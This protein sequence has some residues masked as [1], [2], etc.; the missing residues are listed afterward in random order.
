MNL[1]GLPDIEFAA[2]DPETIKNAV[3]SAAERTHEEATGEKITLYPADPRRLFL[4]TVAEIII[5]QRNLIDYTGKMN[6][7]A[8]ATGD[9]L[10]HLGALLGVE[11][12]PARAARTTV[13]FTLS[14][15]QAR[16]VS[17]PAG[18]RTSA[19][20]NVYFQSLEEA[21]IPAGKA[22][23][24]VS[25][26]CA[27]IGILGN[28]YLPG[29]IK[30]LVDPLP[31][32]QSVVNT[33][34]SEG[35][36]DAED[37]ENYRERIQ[38]A[39]EQY[40]N[41]GSRDAYVSWARRAS[42]LIADVGVHSPS[43]GVVN[44]YPL[45]NDGGLPGQEILD[46]VLAVCNGEDVRPLTDRVFALSPD[47]AEYELKLTWY[48]DRGNATSASSIHNA[49]T[50]AVYDWQLWQ[51]S[52]LGRDINPSELIRK[53]MTAG[54]RRVEV[55]SPAFRVLNFNEVAGARLTEV[56]YGGLEDG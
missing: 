2:K 23:A 13:R 20:G 26:E 44:I 40:S 7:L 22:T 29:Q 38:I 28:G 30:T 55:I 8:Y 5:L 54:A 49:V 21:E 3:I 52:K 35:G 1:L 11:R 33:T 51:R 37:D 17:I 32:I 24:D 45:L 27:G 43:P 9:Y 15:T 47:V 18:T 34:A 36:A 56:N 16:A 48:L 14:V 12:L 10:D 41:A 50:Q 19:G 53:V 46:Q 4:L 39:P 6:L 31:W 25:M 42:P